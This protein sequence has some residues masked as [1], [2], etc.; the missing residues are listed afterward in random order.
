MFRHCGVSCILASTCASR[1][2]VRTFSTAQLLKVLQHCNVFNLLVSTCGSRHNRAQL[3]KS[4][5]SKS[6][7]NQ[8]AVDILTSTCASRHNGVHVLSIST[9][10]SVPNLRSFFYLFT[11]THASTHPP[12]LVNLFSDP[13]EPENFEK[14]C[15]SLP[16]YLFEPLALLWTDSL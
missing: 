12:L 11:S 1:P 9:S 3:F 6:A 14:H 10:K 5:T 2:K 13:P 8:C 16:F 15:A 4:A 7:P